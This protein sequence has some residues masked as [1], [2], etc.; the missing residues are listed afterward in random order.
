M[1]SGFSDFEYLATIV[2]NFEGLIHYYFQSFAFMAPWFRQ[3]GVGLLYSLGLAWAGLTMVKAPVDRFLATFSVLVS[4]AIAGFLCSPTTDT[5][6]LGGAD[7]TELSIGA[8]YSY[9][10]AGSITQ[11]FQEVVEQAWSTATVENNGGAGPRKEAIA[12]AFN[13]KAAEFADKFI[14][15]EGKAAVLDYYKQCGTQAMLQAQTPKEKS[16]LKSVGIGANMLGMGAN[17]AAETAQILLKDRNANPSYTEAQISGVDMEYVQRAPERWEAEAKKIDSDRAEAEEFL[18]KLPPSNSSIDGTKGYRIPTA[19]YY[20]AQFSKSESVDRSNKQAF[21]NVS[22]SGGDL[23]KMTPKGAVTLNSG[24]ASDNMFYPKNCYDL[25]KVASETMSSLREGVRGIPEFDKLQLTGQYTALTAT[26]LARRGLND[27]TNDKHE[28][29][30][31]DEKAAPGL[32]EPIVD[33]AYSMA[34]SI[35]NYFDKWMLQYGIPTTISVMAMIVAILLATFPIFA[36]ISVM[37]GTRVLVSYFKLMA[38]PFVVVFVNNFLLC[39]SAGFIAYNKLYAIVPESL[40][41]GGVDTASAL[42]GMSAESII[43]ATICVCEVAIAKFILWDDVRA[44]TSFSPAAAG[45]AAA[46]RGI[47]F[48]GKALSYVTGAAGKIAAGAKTAQSAQAARGMSQSVASI[49]KSVTAI[50]NAGGRSMKQSSI[51]QASGGQGSGGSS[52]APN[53]TGTAGGANGMAGSSG[54]TKPVGSGNSLNPPKPP[55]TTDQPS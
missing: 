19:D 33:V 48:M 15:G 49:N 2:G 7:G 17:G 42:A 28:K 55:P 37:F 53:S 9:F 16:V 8:Y 31:V 21:K 47:A 43:Y 20:K 13:S 26:A 5:K 4:I 30:G 44:V 40:N 38:F 22:T 1:S 50:A 36:L 29:L 34:T 27:Q 23:G 11:S 24:D 18:K 35:S 25:Y 41:P 51:P 32:V 45:N 10:L 3:V 54:A 46:A 12:M 14:K 52:G 6:N 39:V